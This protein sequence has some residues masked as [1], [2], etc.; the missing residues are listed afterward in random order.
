VD[1]VQLVAGLGLPQESAAALLLAVGTSHLN[2]GDYRKGEISLSRALATPAAIAESPKGV[3]RRA[4]LA[5]ARQGLT[6][7]AG[8]LLDNATP[9]AIS[10][11]DDQYGR[12]TAPY[13]VRAVVE[14]SELVHL[15]GV[16]APQASTPR[17]ALLRPL[18]RFAEVTG[19]LAARSRTTPIGIH[20]GQVVHNT[21]S[22]VWRK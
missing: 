13:V 6:M 21:Q 7:I 10:V 4:A 18:Q 9:P 2:K 16:T 14:H 12:D 15:L 5:A 8:Q 1:A 22:G 19:E 3:R 17:H 20:S 11:L